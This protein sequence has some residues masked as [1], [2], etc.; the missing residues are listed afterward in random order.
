MRKILLYSVILLGLI[1]PGFGKIKVVTSYGYIADITRLIGGEEVSVNALASG[2]MDPH[3]I[4]PKPSFIAKLRKAELLVINGGQLEIGWLPPVIRQ[5][6]NPRINPGQ[7]GLL[8]LMDLV[9]SNDVPEDVSR[10][11]GDVHPEGNPHIQLDP[12]N[13]PVFAKAVMER[14]SRLAPDKSEVF[15]RNYEDF[16]KRWSEKTVLW[17]Q[18][19]S[20]LKGMKVVSYHKLY[21]YLFRRFQI[22]S[23]ETLEPLPGIPP[24][25]RHIAGIIDLIKKENI[26]LIAQ[27]VYHSSKTARFISEKT[28]VKVVILPHD[29]GAVKEVTDIFSLFDEIVRRLTGS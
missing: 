6:N 23:V 11:H 29:V 8:V 5:A 14:L 20:P 25:S 15:K 17:E 27:D 22:E 9:E 19:L 24:T 18:R 4:T 3:F 28:G 13:I 26:A 7:V 16:R 1:S 2:S 10:A 21:D 12:D